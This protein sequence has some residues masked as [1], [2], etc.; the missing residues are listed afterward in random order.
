MS[1]PR[2][3]PSRRGAG[4]TL[5]EMLLAGAILAIGVLGMLAMIF[6][7]SALVLANRE[8]DTAMNLA[9]QQLAG[10]EEYAR[11]DF[12]GTFA[13][14][15]GAATQTLSAHTGQ[16]AKNF[17]VTI[18]FPTGTGAAATQLLEN[19]PVDP[20]GFGM[21]RDLDGNGTFPDADDKAATYSLLP[22]KV[23]VEWDSDFGVV[24]VPGGPRRRSVDTYGLLAKLR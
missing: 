17:D 2:R 18:V 15:R 22:V 21:P 11:G 1:A 10:I 7:A 20:G 23:H 8:D 5:V 4:F 9:C 14:Y 6:G 19:S 13:H 12:S 3:I 16:G 24:M